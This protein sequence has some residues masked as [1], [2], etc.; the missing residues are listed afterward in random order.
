MAYRRPHQRSA[1]FDRLF[2]LSIVVGLFVAGIIVRLFLLQV[3]R[4]GLYVALAEDQH[5]L[6][7]KLV[8][9]RGSIYMRDA[10][11]PSELFAVATNRELKLVFAV[12]KSVSDPKTTTEKLAPILAIDPQYLFGKLNR[13]EDS[14]EVLRH[15]LDP[16]IAEKVEALRLEGIHTTSEMSRYYPF[17]D[18]M[19]QITGFLGFQDDRRIGQ[20]GLEGYFEKELSGEPGFLRAEG[21]KEGRLIS[22]G[23]QTIQEARH[24]DSVVLTID[25]TLQYQVCTKLAAAVEKHGAESG[26]VVVVRPS[27]GAVLAMCNT[28]GF[29]ANKY[30]EAEQAGHYANATIADAY[31][32]GSVMKTMTLAAAINEGKITPETTYEDTGSEVIGKYTLRNSEGKTY[33]VQTMAQ[34]LEESINTGAIFAMRQAGPE[35]FREYLEKFGFGASSGVQLQG[36]RSG[37]ISLLS[38]KGDIYPATASFG[39]G[40]TVTPLQLVMAYAAIANNGVLMKPYIIDEIVKPDGEHIKTE[41]TKVRQVMDAKAA[42]TMRAMLVNVVRKGHGWRAAVQG[43]YIGGKTGTAQIPYADRPGYDPSKN[44]G[45]FVGLGPMTD[46]KFAMIVRINVPRDVLFAENSAAPLFGDIAN[47]LL[48]YERIEPDDTSTTQ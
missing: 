7:E 18:I 16:T 35:K 39:Q 43:Y 27:T 24:G 48:Q 9:V 32:P 38:K 14:Y 36:E 31:E 22:V 13:P 21:D 40:M 1:R 29:D 3:V 23:K 45:T 34:V 47:F 20:Y 42:G 8:P 44:I 6:A 2:G 46:P 12:P 4:H 10:A 19:S 11:S 28:P 25:R 41:P 37:D 30:A 33:G 15:Y 5:G 17:A 26:S